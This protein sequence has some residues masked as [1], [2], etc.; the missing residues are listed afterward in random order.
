[1]IRQYH[2]FGSISF[3]VML[4]VFAV[5]FVIVWIDTDSG[6]LHELSIAFATSLI[7]SAL[8]LLSETFIK[9]VE[10]K[11]DEYIF[12]LR[13]FGIDNLLFHKDSVLKKII[14]KCKNEL[15]ITGYRLIMTSK[16]SFRN[17][18]LKACEHTEGLNIRLLFVPMWSDTYKRV[19]DDDVS[20]C[21]INVFYTLC[22]C[23]TEYG[24][25]VEIRTTEKPMFNDTYKVDDRIITGP[26]L[27][28]ADFLNHR[29]ITAKDFF[30]LDI[31]DSNKEL[32]RL[33]EGDYSAVWE[34]S[35]EKFNVGRL[36]ALLDSHE[37]FESL[38]N[39]TAEERVRLLRSCIET[40]S[41]ISAE[42]ML[43]KTVE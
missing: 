36:I 40:P 38:I 33:M 39:M 18:I 21:Y 16:G 22:R 26:Y 13:S 12:R 6:I 19:Y 2:L 15:W 30:S 34:Q 37:K 29:L 27:H 4:V 43:A 1:M 14:P 11:N 24:A 31:T 5:T 8:C 42:K 17:A 7:A 32:Y 25:E 41:D 35:T 3:F 23:I 28:C 10:S 9:Y 20:L